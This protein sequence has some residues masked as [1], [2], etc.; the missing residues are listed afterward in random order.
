MRVKGYD[1]YKADVRHTE[2]FLKGE[3]VVVQILENGDYGDYLLFDS[4]ER[5]LEYAANLKLWV[6]AVEA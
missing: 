4:E 3:W 5:A 6:E 2:V 1:V